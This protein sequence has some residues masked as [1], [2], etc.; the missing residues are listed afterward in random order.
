MYRI[1][2]GAVPSGLSL[3]AIPAYRI[4]ELA[5]GSEVKISEVAILASALG[6]PLSALAERVE[7]PMVVAA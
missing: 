7:A 2:S 6:K 5:D 3:P 1:R 4:A